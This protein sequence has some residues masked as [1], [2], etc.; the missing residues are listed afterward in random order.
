[1]D[2][3]EIRIAKAEA[4]RFLEKLKIYE[5]LYL[6][7]EKHIKKEKRD[8]NTYYDNYLHA[9]KESEALRRAS[10]DLT[11]ALADMRRSK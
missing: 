8:P 3:K 2:I 9:P 7:L 5:D 4:R 1:M 11:R 10:L 6:E